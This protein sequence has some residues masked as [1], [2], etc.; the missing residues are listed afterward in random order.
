M[1]RLSILAAGVGGQG[2]ITLASTLARAAVA[3]GTKALVAE[4]H[5]L[6]QR[7]GS[8]EVHIRLGDV[9]APLIAPGDADVLIGL[10]LI[11]A[12]RRVSHLR[13]GGLLLAADTI[14]RP[15][16]PGVRV[17][18]REE[19][20]S[21]MRRAAGDAK[22][23]V[24]PARELASKVGGLLFSNMVMLGALA[25]SGILEGFVGVEEL[26]RVI[27]TLRRREENLKAFRL[28]LD[29]CSTHCS[30]GRG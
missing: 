1:G 13:S 15:A 9:H 10:E 26:E 7:G 8:V 22:V 28:G 16:V 5:G 4:T 25:G 17:P 20:V 30:S 2:I 21:A 24:V 14:L 11:E 3:S 27:G 23:V 19:L 29:Y 18:S 12:A 6:S